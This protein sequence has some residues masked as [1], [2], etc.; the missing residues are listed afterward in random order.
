MGARWAIATATQ[1]GLIQAPPSDFLGRCVD[2]L[3]KLGDISMGSNDYAEASTLHSGDA[4]R[5]D[6]TT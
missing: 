4:L 5:L 3:G 6:S 1:A 2:Q